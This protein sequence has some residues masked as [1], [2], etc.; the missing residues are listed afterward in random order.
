MLAVLAEAVDALAEDETVRAVVLAASGKAFCAGHDLK[1]MRAE[2]S[3]DYYQRLF[4]KC[5]AMDAS[6]S[7]AS[8]CL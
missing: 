6:R 3:L 1:E 2:P 5:T 7:S 4:A 8:W